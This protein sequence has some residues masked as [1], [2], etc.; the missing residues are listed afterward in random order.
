MAELLTMSREYS[1]CNNHVLEMDVQVANRCKQQTNSKVYLFL[2]IPELSNISPPSP[3]CF[4]CPRCSPICVSYQLLKWDHV[5]V[6]NSLTLSTQKNQTLHMYNLIHSSGPVV[7]IIYYL[8]CT[9]Y[10]YI[11]T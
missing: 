1:A 8:P 5:I 9:L 7:P 6:F 11:S 2:Y 10:K 3:V 4:A